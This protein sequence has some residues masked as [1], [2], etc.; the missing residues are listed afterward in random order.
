MRNDKL[1]L[2]A[3]VGAALLA[4][5][6]QAENVAG[7][8]TSTW[9]CESC[10]FQKDYEA[11]ATAGVLYVDEDSAKY[12]EYNGLDQKG[13]YADV[14]AR[15]G[16]R[17]ESGAYYRY[18]LKDLGLDTREARFVAGKEGV[19]EGTLYYDELPHRVW[20]TTI[21]PY[22]RSGKD[23]LVLPT[24]W[25]R[26]G[27][28]SGM[29]ALSQSLSPVDIGTDRTTIGAGLAYLFGTDL[30]F[31]ANYSRQ[32]IE[33]SKL[34]S[35]NFLFLSLQYPEPVDAAHDQ[36]EAGA[37]YRWKRGFARLSWYGSS[38]DNS[39]SSL[40]F[41]NP[42]LPAAPDTVLGRKAGAPD[43]KAQTFALDG[44]F[45]LPWWNSVL[46]YRL[47]EGTMDQSEDFLPFSTSAALDATALLPRQDLNA[48]VS[49]SHYRA[50]LS[51]RPHPRLRAHV[52]YRYDER[53]DGT[54]DFSTTGFV[55][56]DSVIGG[57]ASARRYSY[58]RTRIDGY[59]EARV[60]DWLS[61]GAGAE[62]NKLERSNQE[63]S[64]TKEERSY[65]ELRMRPWGSIEVNG[66]YGNANV[67]AGD[68]TVISGPLP[69]NPL[70]RKFN[71][72]DRDSDFSELRF[73]WAPWKLAIALEGRY[74]FDAYR[75][76]PL[77]L[78]SGRDYRYAG[79]VSMPVGE[80]ASVYVSGSYQNIATEQVGQEVFP[81][82]SSVWRISHEDEFTTAGGGVVWKKLADKVD[83]RLDYT[84]GKSQGPI[85]TL[86]G[87]AAGSEAFPKLQTELNSVRL[88]ASY[89]IN[90]RLRVG[91]AWTWED[92]SSSDWQIAGVQPAT[93]GNLLGMGADPYDYSV[94][95]IGVSFTYRFGPSVNDE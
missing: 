85:D 18:A 63:T 54:A 77:G 38:Y 91:A 70:L 31:F 12:G 81:G 13:A 90:E 84:Y 67:K 48:D 35:A 1:I 82:Y 16:S 95:V 49:T 75:K 51:V 92:Y 68:Y 86:V 39:V 19:V 17:T 59:G 9:V 43:N 94:N 11:R 4:A 74:S 10:P 79:T 56:S 71:Q 52:G 8:D 14:S 6:A 76:S 30:K 42:Y 55:E 2:A 65:I 41:D 89:P 73:A 78:V 53:D 32:E 66:R 5:T 47:A 36:V 34:A 64:Q 69:E 23:T 93:L 83:V 7:V 33:G 37:T 50:S 44:N 60:F 58:K 3:A 80:K 29:T 27:S 61:I 24:D 26:S 28:T 62:S 87:N 21:T 40:T 15:G 20:D 22:S 25:V 57:P 46:S 45:L 72:A 88:S